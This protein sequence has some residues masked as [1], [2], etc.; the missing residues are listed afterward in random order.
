MG[1]RA[2][3]EPPTAGAYTAIF[4]HQASRRGIPLE[5]PVLDHILTKYRVERR[6]MK[7]C[8]PRDLLDRATDICLFE[9]HGL[10]LTPH[11]VD[12]AWRNYFGTSHSFAPEQTQETMIERTLADPLEL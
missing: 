7:G 5:Q 6:Q 11:I 1:Y 3:V 9:K 12:I 10:K 4:K 2:R 8:E